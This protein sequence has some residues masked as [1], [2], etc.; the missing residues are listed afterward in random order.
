M[1]G[2]TERTLQGSPQHL[3][4]GNVAQPPDGAIRPDIGVVFGAP[5]GR[6]R[7][8][9]SGRVA[10][11]ELCVEAGATRTDVGNRLNGTS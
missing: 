6:A 7:V 8:R 1:R 9:T 2:R 5:C 10:R 3:R 11:I 4:C